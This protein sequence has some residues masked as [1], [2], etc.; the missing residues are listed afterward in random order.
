MAKTYPAG[1][2]VLEI[3]NWDRSTK[4]HFGCTVHPG[5]RWAS[6]EPSWSSWF[7]TNCDAFGNPLEDC[8]CKL[9]SGN[10]V[11]LDEYTA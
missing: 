11:T 3:R 8:D 5:S 1:T 4:V 2:P 9:A 6:K 7:S 10:F